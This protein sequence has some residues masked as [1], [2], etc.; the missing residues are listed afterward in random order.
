MKRYLR[1]TKIL[2]KDFGTYVQG[3][4]SRL[5]EASLATAR[6]LG[7]KVRYLASSQVSKE[8][9]ARGIAEEHGIDEG[10]VCVLTCVEPCFGFELYRNRE[11]K[12]LDVWLAWHTPKTNTE[13]GSAN[14]ST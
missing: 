3:V 10:L 8:D 12:R 1:H 2:L 14:D 4:S 13:R 5:K 11:T 6:A 9:V 7:R